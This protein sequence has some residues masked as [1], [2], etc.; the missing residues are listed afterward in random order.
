M[1]IRLDEWLKRNFDPPPSMHTGRAMIKAGRIHPAPTKMG[2]SWYVDEGAV[3]TEEWLRPPTL[4][5]R[6][7]GKEE[8][9]KL[10]SKKR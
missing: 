7:F 4:A 6:V 10:Y 9:K 2:R 8:V 3:L 1:K 5:E